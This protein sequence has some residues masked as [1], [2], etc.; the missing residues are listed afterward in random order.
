LDTSE[1][2]GYRIK[3]HRQTNDADAALLLSW[4]EK[5]Y[6]KPK[7]PSLSATEIWKKELVE[8]ADKQILKSLGVIP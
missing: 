3:S 1:V 7:A 4:N 8:A 6:P 2:I 5:N